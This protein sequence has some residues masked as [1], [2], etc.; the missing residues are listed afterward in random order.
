[1]TPENTLLLIG[2][3]ARV[4]QKAK[5]LGLDVILFQ[6]KTKYARQQADL[7]DMTFIGDITDWS[8]ARKVARAAY[9]TWGFAA[10]L[11]LTDPG[12]EAAARINDE[13][14]LGGTGYDVVR[15]F[16]DKLEMRRLLADTDLAIGAEPLTD[17]AGL[18]EFA[19]RYGYPV[20]VKPVDGAASL[21]VHRIDGPDDIGGVLAEVEDLRATGTTRGCGALFTI[22]DHVLE[23]YVSGPEFSVECFSFHGRHVVIAIT[24]KLMA[25]GHFAELGHTVPARITATDEAAVEDTVVRFL[26]LMG[27]R[28]GPS[29]T[30]FKLT[31]RGP[32][33]IESHNRIGGDRL[34]DVVAAVHGVDQQTYA[35]GW[36]FGLV[37]ELP[38]R[39][40]GN[41]A[42]SHRVLRGAPGPVVAINGADEVRAHPDTLFL[43]VHV[44]VGDVI[45]E[46]R[47]NHDSIGWV[48]VTGPDSNAA[49][50]LCDEMVGETLRIEVAGE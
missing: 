30:E 18:E 7:A 2:A 45:P 33:I 20:I 29:H 48:A 43:D 5:A 38:G 36:P 31:P 8:V 13:Y 6:H 19:Q 37:E 1:M 25:D 39:P 34:D 21:G 41:G 42:A 46:V 16:L 24:E 47:D 23:E 27:L 14:G 12:V 4:I 3:P 40:A 15:R 35:V 49:V 50:K 22:G 32:V 44:Q 28:D 10:A 9:E 17:R 26:D 11:S